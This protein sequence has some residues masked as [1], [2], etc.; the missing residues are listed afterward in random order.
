MNT[1]EKDT[2]AGGCPYRSL[3]DTLAEQA[4]PDAYAEVLLPWLDANPDEAAW[5]ASLRERGRDG[6]PPLEAEE[7]WRLYALSRLCEF[8]VLHVHEAGDAGGNGAWLSMPALE[9]FLIR[10]GIDVLRPADYHAFHHEVVHLVPVPGPQ[11]RPSIL[12]YAWPCLMLGSLLLMRGGVKVSAGE[13]VLA[14]GIA[15]ASTLY[16]TYHRN[17]RPTHDLAHG[18]GSNSSWRTAFRRDYHLA[19]QFHFNVDGPTDLAL[20]NPAAVD[21]HGLG[22]DERVEL[23]VHRSFVTSPREDADLFPYRDRF[24][25]ASVTTASPRLPFWKK[26]FG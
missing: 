8:L 1:L 2:M 20:A 16:W 14:P 6:I 13:R 10:L 3:L 23:L 18:W 5:L 12:A 7:L 11:Q 25:T 24:S 21:S 4:A 26:L 22:K 9:D 19:G 17:T 15:D